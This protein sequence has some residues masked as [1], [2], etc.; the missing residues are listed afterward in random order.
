MKTRYD[1]NG[2]PEVNLFSIQHG[3][4]TTINYNSFFGDPT[5]LKQLIDHEI[6]SVQGCMGFF[7]SYAESKHLSD[8]K[9]AAIAGAIAE[10]EAR[11]VELRAHRP[12]Y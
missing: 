1:P 12:Q 7:K 8:K 4:Y 5:K 2:G 9:R 11:L 6:T 10:D 3:H